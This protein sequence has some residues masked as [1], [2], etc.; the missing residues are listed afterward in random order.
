MASV[1]VGILFMFVAG[2]TASLQLVVSKTMQTA[3]MPYY[4][5][6]SMSSG[7]AAGV[8]AVM[9]GIVKAPF[10]ERKSLIWILMRG[11]SSNFMLAT[12]V[13]GVQFG[14]PS[15]DVA[16][17]SSV[18]TVFAALLGRVFLGEPLQLAHI[19]SVLCCMTGGVLISKP[20]FLF[21]T[22]SNTVPP[23]AYLMAVA[24]GFW[25]A[26]L[27]VSARKAGNA[28]PWFLNVF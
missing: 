17:V 19:A 3:G 28:S 18:S 13:A 27:A 23:V 26:V 22:G 4:K 2:F 16:A 25:S 12:M 14:A 20:E 9:T 24:C 7:L 11:L 21:G 10:P 8:F 5:M 15:G 1:T 6:L